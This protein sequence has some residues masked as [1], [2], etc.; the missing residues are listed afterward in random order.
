[1]IHITSY[2]E[3]HSEHPLPSMHC[4]IRVAIATPPC[5]AT[6]RQLTMGS[7]FYC[8]QQVVA[9]STANLQ[10]PLPPCIPKDNAGV[11]FNG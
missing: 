1:M 8:L 3:I 6:L 7:G 9:C 4:M 5:S 2:Q 11:R 10:H